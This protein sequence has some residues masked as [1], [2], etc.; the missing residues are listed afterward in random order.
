MTM[1]KLLCLALAL[2]MAL[3]CTALAENDLQAQLDA[4]NAKI[5]E[6]QAQVDA[7]YPY[8]FAQIVAT[9]GEDGII[10]LK[11]AQAE[12]DNMNAQYAAYG[13]DLASMGM[14]DM[15]KVSVVEAAVEDAVI[16]AKAEELGLAQLD[17]A[18]M[19]DLNALA[20]ETLNYY[21]D[22]YLS[23]AYADAEEITDEMKAEAIAY[24]ESTGTSLDAILQSCI[25]SEVYQAV[26]EYAFKD[27]AVTE[28]DIQ[29]AYQEMIQD[30]QDAY[31]DDATYNSDRT[32][33]EAIAWNPEGYRAVKHVLVKFSDEQSAR[34]T[35]LQNQIA[36][37]NAEKEAIENPAE[38]TEEAAEAAAA[39]RAIEEINADIAACAME[40][41]ALYSQLLPTAQEVVEK[42]NAGTSFEDLIAEYNADP[43]MTNEPTASQGYAVREGSTYW[44]PAFTAGAMSI[45]EIG[46]ISEPVYG[47]FG[48]HVIYYMADVPAGEVALE[49]IRDT[50]EQNALSD[51]QNAAYADLIASWIDE[52]NVE[53]HMENFGVIQ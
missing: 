13:M 50:V 9:Y 51:K 4:A 28:E 21:V 34:Y 31:T 41:E 19:A 12:Y 37:L 24:W 8:Y 6:L 11:D 23:Q 20:E 52:M 26:E 46:G 17:E 39:P 38:E 36:S 2:A 53:Y 30:N 47:K 32:N 45:A 3:C 5:A 18:T 15:A 40:V 27:V 14:A 7:Y 33:A 25:D 10:W 1:K 44:D 16:K 35:E 49:E 43:G 22:Y 42:F 29:A 48:I